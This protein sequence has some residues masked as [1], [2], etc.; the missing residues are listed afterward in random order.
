MG[1]DTWFSAT[2]QSIASLT[3]L[4]LRNAST[5][6]SHMPTEMN[7]LAISCSQENSDHTHYSRGS[8]PY[9][10]SRRELFGGSV[11]TSSFRDVKSSS[12]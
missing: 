5:A 2:Q 7:F 10:T 12:L 6:S 8:T 1:E 3:W 9:H 11:A 4:A